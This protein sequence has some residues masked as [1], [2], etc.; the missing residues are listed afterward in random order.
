MSEEGTVD[1]M[2]ADELPT[3]SVTPAAV[4]AVVAQ[5][6][7]TAGDVARPVLNVQWVGATGL[8]GGYVQQASELHFQDKMAFTPELKAIVKAALRTKIWRGTPLDGVTK[9]QALADGISDYLHIPHAIVEI[10][11]LAMGAGPSYANGVCRLDKVSLVSMLHEYAHHILANMNLPQD[12]LF[13]RS[14][15]LGLYKAV[16]P[17]LFEK[18]LTNGRLLFTDETSVPAVA[19]G[20]VVQFDRNHINVD[21]NHINDIIRRVAGTDGTP[22]PAAPSAGS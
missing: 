5:T 11:P 17:K 6:S 18:A 14:F 1:P 9:L 21:M 4:P 13:P 2:P 22:P 15:S 7:A 20:G 16:A 8:L 10:H 3:P 12:E 19:A